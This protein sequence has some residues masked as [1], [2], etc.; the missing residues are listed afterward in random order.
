MSTLA[1]ASIVFA[2]VFGSALLGIRMGTALP[3][4]H[5]SQD[6]KDVVKLGTALIATMAALVISLL[7]SSAKSSF[8]KQDNEIK[9]ASANVVLLDR[10]LAKYGP[11][12]KD[13][14]EL[15]RRSLTLKVNQVWP[16]DG[17]RAAPLDRVAEG[18]VMADSVEDKIRD[19]APRNDT[20]RSL[21]SR[22]LQISGDFAQ[23]RWLLATQLGQGSIPVP[24]LV[25][26]VVWLAVI[27][28]SFGLFAPH[29]AT[30]ITVL[31]LCAL[32]ASAAIFLL[33]EMDQPFQGWLKIS[34][35]PLRYAIAHLG[36]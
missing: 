7:I 31:L 33:L 11:E 28:A 3:A 36:Q 13:I 16:E 9:Q 19:L 14:R 10:V 18:P 26:L 4:H 30:V 1:I 21:Q 15:L 35:A 12:T 34:S 29:N 5:L 22:A 27:F 20:Q 32:S 6:S 17:S 25:I 23:T 2:C 24:F 8:D